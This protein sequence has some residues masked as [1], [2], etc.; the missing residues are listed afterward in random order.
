M[1]PKMSAAVILAA[2]LLLP[3]WTAAHEPEPDEQQA[4]EREHAQ[5][6]RR[7]REELESR[8]A[9][10]ARRLEAEQFRQAEMRRLQGIHSGI[11]RRESYLG[12]EAYWTQRERDSLSRDPSDLSAMARR[13]NIDHQLYQYHNE[14]ERAGTLRQ[15][16]TTPLNGLQLR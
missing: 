14:L 4:E 8:R 9:E 6:L 16:V 2:L 5:K 15:G 13:T 10:A 1:R 3:G 12:H 7:A 11:A